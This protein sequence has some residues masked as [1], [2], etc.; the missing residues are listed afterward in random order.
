MKALGLSRSI[1]LSKSG[2]NTLTETGQLDKNSLQYRGYQ[3][4]LDVPKKIVATPYTDNAQ[5]MEMFSEEMQH[6]DYGKATPEEAAKSFLR[7]GN[8]LLKKLTR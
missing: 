5:L 6:I 4:A 2:L 3:Q 7:K 8:R 1:P